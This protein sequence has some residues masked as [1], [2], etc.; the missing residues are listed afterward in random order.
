M[1]SQSPDSLQGLQFS[2]WQLSYCSLSMGRT[3]LTSVAGT[4]SVA[5]SAVAAAEV[6]TVEDIASRSEDGAW[7]ALMETFKTLSSVLKCPVLLLIHC[8]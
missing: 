6:S 4:G 2:A 5:S 8:K 3:R 1:A 7:E